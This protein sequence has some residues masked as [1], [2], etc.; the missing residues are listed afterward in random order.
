MIDVF[1]TA[2]KYFQ[3]WQS[4]EYKHYIAITGYGD[5]FFNKDGSL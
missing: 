3:S 1:D 2:D 5:P 4:W